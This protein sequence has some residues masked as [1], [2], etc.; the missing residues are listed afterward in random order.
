MNPHMIIAVGAILTVVGIILF[1][2]GKSLQNKNSQKSGIFTLIGFILLTV[3]LILALTAIR[4]L[5]S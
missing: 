5:F 1:N 2:I 4:V 3:G